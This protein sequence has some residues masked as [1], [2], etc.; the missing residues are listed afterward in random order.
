MGEAGDASPHKPFSTGWSAFSFPLLSRCHGAWS[1][2][3]EER[4]RGPSIPSL[5]PPPLRGR[6]RVRG[7]FLC[8]SEEHNDACPDVRPKG[9]ISSTRPCRFFAIH[10]FPL[11]PV[12]DV[13]YRGAGGNDNVKPPTASPFFGFLDS[14][15]SLSPTFVI[16]E[17]AGMTREKLA[18]TTT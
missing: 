15:L 5:F 13:R 10:G 2:R 4:M 11:K 9:R 17:P 3:G 6:V 12:P 16:G 14:R 18:G 1:I 7:V 8:R